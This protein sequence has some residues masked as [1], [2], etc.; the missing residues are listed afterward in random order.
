MSDITGLSALEMRPGIAV[1]TEP[2]NTA[3]PPVA[4]ASADS[5][6]KLV[7][8]NAPDKAGADPAGARAAKE[9]EIMVISSF[10]SDALKSADSKVFGEGFS[11][12]F[13]SQIFTKA[14]AERIVDNGGFGIAGL[15]TKD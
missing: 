11:G 6:G 2:A 8:A 9:F 7:S 13:Y 14:V 1:A 15:V 12:E 10:L 3:S 4:G 5:F